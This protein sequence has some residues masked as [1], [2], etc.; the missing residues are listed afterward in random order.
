MIK[1][2]VVKSG[3]TPSVI[4]GKPS[5]KT[6]KEGEAL[7]KNEFVKSAAKVEKCI[8]LVNVARGKEQ[9]KDK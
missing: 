5:E 6:N 9:P 8:G 4:S 3:E 1:F 7:C 2:G